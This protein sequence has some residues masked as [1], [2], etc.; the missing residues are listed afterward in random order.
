MVLRFFPTLQLKKNKI[1]K[2][3]WKNDLQESLYSGKSHP[4]PIAFTMSDLTFFEIRYYLH[5]LK[6][7][8]IPHGEVLL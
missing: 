8:K 1:T 2:Q 4:R 6:T 5:K 7:V 3:G